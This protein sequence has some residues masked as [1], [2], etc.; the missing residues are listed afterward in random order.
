MHTLH[1]NNLCTNG[2]YN[3]LI[4]DVAPVKNLYEFVSAD[5][6]LIIHKDQ[7]FIKG[8]DGDL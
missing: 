6:A 8:L 2:R 1:P 7:L 3:P 5:S 4:F